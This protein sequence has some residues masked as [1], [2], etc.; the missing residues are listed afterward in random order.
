MPLGSTVQVAVAGQPNA[1]RAGQD[2]AALTE[3]ALSQEN[4]LKHAGLCQAGCD[5]CFWKSAWRIDG[6]SHRVTQSDP[7]RYSFLGVTRPVRNKCQGYLCLI[8][9]LLDDGFIV[10]RK[11]R[12][13][14]V[15]IKTNGNHPE[16]PNERI[17]MLIVSWKATNKNGIVRMAFCSLP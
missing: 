13:I 15:V 17:N 5:N 16:T 8:N 6:R 4:C 11:I 10:S 1:W 9:T 14:T 7:G 3:S 12:Q 2:D